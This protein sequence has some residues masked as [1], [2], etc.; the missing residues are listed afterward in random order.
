VKA[1]TVAFPKKADR[2]AAVY[3]V[4]ALLQF[5]VLR[6]LIVASAGFRWHQTRRY[7]PLT[8]SHIQD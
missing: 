4:S 3:S 6:A 1:G 8:F 5:R 7:P 2:P